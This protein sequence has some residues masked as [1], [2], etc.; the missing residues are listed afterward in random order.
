MAFRDDSD[1]LHARIESLERELEEAR[2]KLTAL[3][4]VEAERSRLQDRV[5]ELEKQL[6]IR[7]EAKE[8]ELLKAKLREEERRSN[9]SSS[10]RAPRSP[11]TRQRWLLAA[12]IA[13]IVL[14]LGVWILLRPTTGILPIAAPT[15]GLVDL[16]ATPI[17]TPVQGTTT[18]TAMAGFDCAGYIP[19][20]PQIVLRTR[21]TQ[22]VRI[23]PTSS[24][25][26]VLVVVTSDGRTLCDDDDGD[27]LN[28]MITTSLP[29]GDTHV[30]VGTYH[31]DES[32]DF[33]L[34]VV[35]TETDLVADESGL[36]P[37]A[38]PSIARVTIP[39]GGA[40]QLSYG[41]VVTSAWTDASTLSSDCRG[42]VPLGP[43]LVVQLEQES[44]LLLTATATEDLVMLMRGP[45]GTTRCDDDSG[46]GNA[47]R[48]ASL[49]GPGAYTIW[50]G[51]YSQQSPGAAVSFALTGQVTAMATGAPSASTIEALPSDGTELTIHG[52]T[53]GEVLS[54]DLG[55]AADCQG[56]LPARAQVGLRVD[57]PH[58]VFLS[59]RVSGYVP[60]ALVRHPD[61]RFECFFGA[62][63]AT[64]QVGEHQLF[65]GMPDETRP[66]E[67]ELT[68]RAAP[69][70]LQPW[71]R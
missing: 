63:H 51:T 55:G 60:P 25:D 27:G 2:E 31:E 11:E 9:D 59:I 22:L 50:V 4:G 61:G 10:K 41:S 32:L 62:S 40:Q 5:D 52:T 20:A 24:G 8:K 33:S 38:E 49:L 37:S 26:L 46:E 35:A 18:G 42:Y 69:P 71:T 19:S 30:F 57:A 12:G 6:G 70:S 34:L 3:E 67:F 58:D 54:R 56:L 65:I 17:P 21:E 39:E 64:W 36:A 45:D 43:H 66:A 47:P 29:P 68:A 13:L 28:P 1:A 16:D 44:T 23:A 53:A 48:L 14:S 15:L 7:T